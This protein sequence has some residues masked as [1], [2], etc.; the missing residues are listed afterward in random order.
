SCTQ[1]RCPTNG[2]RAEVQ[3]LS[4]ATDSL[5]DAHSHRRPGDMCRHS[6]ESGNP[7]SFV[8]RER[9][10]IP[11]LARDDAI[12]VIPAKAGIQCRSYIEKHTGSRVSLALAQDDAIIVIPAKAGIQC[13]SFIEQ[14]TGSGVSLAL[15]RDDAIIVI[16]AQAGTPVLTLAADS[17][18]GS[19]VSLALS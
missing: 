14:H 5:S 9:H 17:P 1:D 15:A 16:P 3:W 11:G 12:I 19:R 18:L 4:W 6:R 13:R 10:W 8:H 7:V 2:R